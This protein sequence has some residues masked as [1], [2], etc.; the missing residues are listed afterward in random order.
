MFILS[1][2]ALIQIFYICYLY[3]MTLNLVYA[4]LSWDTIVLQTRQEVLIGETNLI[5]LVLQGI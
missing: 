5:L 3:H 2:I 4:G 1:V